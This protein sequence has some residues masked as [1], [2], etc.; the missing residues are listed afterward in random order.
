V[1][2]NASDYNRKIATLMEDKA[3]KKLKKDPTD[4]V[5]RKTVLIKKSPGL[6]RRFAKSYDHKVPDH[7]DSMGCR[8][9]TSLM[10]H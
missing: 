4:S 8:K 9:S 7:L 2:L 5:E 10:F 6:L 1:V 3:Y